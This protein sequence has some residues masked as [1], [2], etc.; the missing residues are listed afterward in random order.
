MLNN[1]IVCFLF[2]LKKGNKQP[3]LVIVYKI[4]IN[5]DTDVNEL[6]NVSDN[7]EY[8]ICSMKG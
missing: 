1:T 3:N 4:Y 7:H 5:N 2:F 8:E 6:N